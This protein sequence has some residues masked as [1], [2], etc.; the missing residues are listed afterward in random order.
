MII[1]KITGGLGNQ[2]FQYS[3]GQYLSLKFKTELRFD[4]QTNYNSNNFTNRSVGLNNFNINLSQATN[5]E[6]SKFKYFDTGLF[7]RLER[8]LIQKLPFLNSKYIVQDLNSTQ[9]NETSYKNDCYYE[10]Y[11]Q[12]YKYLTLN[13]PILRN[14]I[15]LK[16][17]LRNG[18][19]DIISTIES[20]QS[21]SLHVRR[22]DYI[23]IKDNFELLGICSIKYYREAIQYFT[24]QHSNPKFFIFSDDFSWV[25]KKFIGPQYVYIEGNQPAQDMYLMALCKHN[26]IANSTFSWWAAWLNNNP[27]KIVIAPANW[28]KGKLNESTINLIPPGWVRI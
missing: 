26:I 8:K 27:D 21:I 3:F 13:E 22:G 11:W 10:G 17:F 2:L 7:F 25:K 28:Y 16:H 23:S 24:R 6:I 20:S 4:I 14:E 9:N 12:S 15:T 18:I 1:V 5:S 19:A